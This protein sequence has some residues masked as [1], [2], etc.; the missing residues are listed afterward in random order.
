[1]PWNDLRDHSPD[2]ACWCHPFEDYQVDDVMIHKAMDGR[3]KYEQM[4]AVSLH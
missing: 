3:E 1:M 4:G 2:C